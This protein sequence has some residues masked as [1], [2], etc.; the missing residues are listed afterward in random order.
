MVDGTGYSTN[1]GDMFGDVLDAT[2]CKDAEGGD[3]GRT[4]RNGQDP[5]TLF[6]V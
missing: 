4:S 1:A 3:D 6:Q 2:S 5:G